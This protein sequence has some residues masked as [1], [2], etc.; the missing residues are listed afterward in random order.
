MNG[1]SEHSHRQNSTDL[2]R[3]LQIYINELKAEIARIFDDE[4]EIRQELDSPGMSKQ[5]EDE[6]A[7]HEQS[8]LQDYELERLH[9][10]KKQELMATLDKK[11]QFLSSQIE[12]NSQLNENNLQLKEENRQL[13]ERN[14]QLE[15]ENRQLHE[16]K[17]QFEE[18]NRQL[19]EGNFQLKENNR[20]LHEVNHQLEEERR[21]LNEEIDLT[22]RVHNTHLDSVTDQLDTTK[23]AKETLTNN[24]MELRKQHEQL[25]NE[26]R[27][28]IQNI[29]QFQCTLEENKNIVDNL[30]KE[31]ES[32]RRQKKDLLDKINEVSSLLHNKLSKVVTVEEQKQQLPPTIIGKHYDTKGKLIWW[33]PKHA[34]K[35]LTAHDQ[36]SDDIADILRR[37]VRDLSEILTRNDDDDKIK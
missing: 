17:F 5:V 27:A 19:H 32:L 34:R 24:I 16:G 8:T 26:C 3:I 7:R 25:N 36:L 11:T 15:E 22:W 2:S 18:E 35:L 1:T 12:N 13:H 6:R 21:C 28:H 10:N 31:N 33:P 23:A 9:E 29:S 14:F 20:Q 37:L 30:S 4:D